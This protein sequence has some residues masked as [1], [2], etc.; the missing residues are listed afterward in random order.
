M[1]SNPLEISPKKQI[2][3]NLT[4]SQAYNKVP[5]NANFSFFLLC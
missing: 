5:Q 2:I 4:I 3:T 1:Q